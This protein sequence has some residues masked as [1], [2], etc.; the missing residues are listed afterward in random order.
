[1]CE[2]G[3]YHEYSLLGKLDEVISFYQNERHESWVF[4]VT[5]SRLFYEKAERISKAI[6]DASTYLSSLESS[7]TELESFRNDLKEYVELSIPEIK[8]Q[9]RDIRD[10]KYDYYFRD[11]IKD[12]SELKKTVKL[13][14]SETQ[15]LRDKIP[16]KFDDEVFPLQLINEEITIKLAQDAT[17]KIG[18]GIDRTRD[19]FLVSLFTSPRKPTRKF[20]ERLSNC[21][22]WGFDPECVMLC[23]SVIDT[24]FRERISV[25]GCEEILGK[26]RDSNYTLDDRICVAAKKGIIDESTKAIATEVRLR[27]NK[28]VHDQPDITKNVF[29]TIK[30]TVIV[31]ERLYED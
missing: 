27:G 1:M 6:I 7:S 4:D 24:A 31:L 12:L 15:P 26:R 13:V 10:E 9:I 11:G 2:E 29:D 28:A 19:L 3:L 16:G 8:N 17:N 25:E 14:S 5:D 23:R 20:M 30:K 22:I 18:E 21:Y